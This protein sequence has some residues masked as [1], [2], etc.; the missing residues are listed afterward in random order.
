M[1]KKMIK[2]L[3]VLLVSAV[4]L[5]FSGCVNLK[6]KADVVKLY[7]L[8]PVEAAPETTA[9]GPSMYVARPN[10]PG[11]LDGKR[12]QFRSANGEVEELSKARWAEPLEDGIAR[13]LA[14]YLQH[15]GGRKVSGFYPWP[16]NRDDLEL[17]VHIYKLGALKSGEVSMLVEWELRS[18]GKA[19]SAG[20]FESQG[21]QWQQG[22]SD[23]FVAGINRALEQ[24]ASDVD[25]AL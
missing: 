15:K 14:E 16:K 9:T 13:A 20:T 25:A 23:S 8:G 12:L 17:R 18:A 19:R 5:V 11:F 2:F 22:D 3:S 4:C 1:N 10:L 21:I 6:P 24:L 7:A